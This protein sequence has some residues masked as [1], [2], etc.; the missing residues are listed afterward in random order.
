MLRLIDIASIVTREP[1]FLYTHRV[2]L[3]PS[4]LFLHML[5]RSPARSS[6][7]S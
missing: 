6:P 3:Y 5:A 1:P 2:G 4:P 7:I